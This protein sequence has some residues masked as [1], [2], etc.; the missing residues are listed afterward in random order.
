MP[1]FGQE[2]MQKT[3][4]CFVSKERLLCVK[5][6]A[7]ALCFGKW[8]ELKSLAICACSPKTRLTFKSVKTIAVASKNKVEGVAL[9]YR[10]E[11]GRLQAQK[12]VVI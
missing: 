3:K 11:K 7:V 2:S 12:K 8:T 10:L 4:G 5:K 6:A 1:R 9:N